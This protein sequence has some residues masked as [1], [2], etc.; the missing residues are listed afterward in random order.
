MGTGRPVPVVV[1]ARLCNDAAVRVTLLLLALGSATAV[2]EPR[3]LD[4][5][6][7]LAR[8]ELG[9]IAG[10]DLTRTSTTALGSTVNT[11]SAEVSVLA[12]YGI[13]QWFSAG[14]GYSI[15]VYNRLGSLGTM[16]LFG[17]SGFYDCGRWQVAASIRGSLDLD[18]E[19][20][21]DL[22]LGLA[23]RYRLRTDVAVFTGTPWSPGPHGSQ[24]RFEANDRSALRLPIG[25]QMQLGDHVALDLTTAIAR[26]ALPSGASATIFE[27]TP[28]AAGAWITLPY[29]LSVRASIGT[30]DL[31]ER[32]DVEAS[33]AVR[34][35]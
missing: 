1:S 3:E 29:K 35:R 11:T 25:L 5:P 7:T 24:L 26:L 34:Y 31:G 9:A 6:L 22:E 27:E 19:H 4:R 30:S 2:A 20:R 16:S 17:T 33:L 32:D 15:P 18:S 14:A 28:F 12:A 13:H 21:R 23:A 8:G 10:F